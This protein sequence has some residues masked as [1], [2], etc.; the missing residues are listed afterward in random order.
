MLSSFLTNQRGSC[1]VGG[2][3]FK[4]LPRETRSVGHGFF[5]PTMGSCH[6]FLGWWSGEGWGGERSSQH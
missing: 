1:E 4:G 3:P 2:V 5:L 6:L